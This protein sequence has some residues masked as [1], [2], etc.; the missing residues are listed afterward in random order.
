[1]RSRIV[2]VAAALLAVVLL[3]MPLAQLP[4][5]IRSFDEAMSAAGVTDPG[6]ERGSRRPVPFS[7]LDLIRGVEV[8]EAQVT[9]DVSVAS[10]DGQMLTVD[11]Y[12]PSRMSS[13]LFP[14]LVQLY[15]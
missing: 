6:V 12:R 14:V 10:I 13:Q 2:G 5:T 7:A 11:V 4:G 15:G 8:G 1:G 9:R 3:A